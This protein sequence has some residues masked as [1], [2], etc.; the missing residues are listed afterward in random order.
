[1]LNTFR[2]LSSSL[3]LIFFGFF[4]SAFSCVIL[5]IAYIIPLKQQ[6]WVQT[7]GI[8]QSQKIIE[9][10]ELNIKSDKITVIP[11]LVYSYT[12]N[13]VTYHSNDFGKSLKKFSQEAQAY[14]KNYKVGTKIQCFYNP[15][16]PTESNVLNETPSIGFLI[17]PVVF[18]F[19]GVGIMCLGFFSFIKKNTPNAK[20]APHDSPS[21]EKKTQAEGAPVIPKDTP[22]NEVK[23]KLKYAWIIY[24]I[25]AI[26][27][28]IYTIFFLYPYVQASMIEHWVATPCTILESRVEKSSSGKS[29]TTYTPIIVYKYEVDSRR[30]GGSKIAL[31]PSS[32]SEAI[33]ICN[34]YKKG[35]Q[36]TCYYNP[37][38]PEEVI[39]NKK[40]RL[41]GFGIL[42]G[43]FFVG[44]PIVF[45]CV[46]IWRKRKKNNSSNTEENIQTVIN[47]TPKDV[48]QKITPV[49]GKFSKHLRSLSIVIGI[50]I[51]LSIVLPLAGFLISFFD[52]FGMQEFFYEKTNSAIIALPS[53]VDSQKT[54]FTVRYYVDK[55]PY[56]HTFNVSSFSTQNKMTKCY[57]TKD[58]FPLFYDPKNPKTVILNKPSMI[59]VVILGT[60]IIILLLNLIRFIY[61]IM[62]TVKKH[63]HS[64][65]N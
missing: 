25:V 26:F 32:S 61:S 14:N 9:D 37:D 33:K 21:F 28:I 29:G 31:G 1:M 42:F 3:P 15:E 13:G 35:N 16:D 2:K 7:T 39:L 55:K 20:E 19:I 5:Y 10:A 57:H 47:S 6:N 23:T 24:I 53:P 63:S 59:L 34:F 56:E 17:I 60:I 51:C 62:N 12:V 4:F 41:D 52:N 49:L 45:A 44:I 65:E 43:V 54:N 48:V 58:S 50:V 38:N 30:Y 27:P 22:Q 18:F 40:Y 46:A 36:Y 11:E 8:V 64:E